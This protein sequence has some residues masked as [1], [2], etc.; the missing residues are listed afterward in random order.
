MEEDICINHNILT[1]NI[2]PHYHDFIEFVYVY[3]GK[4]VHSIDGK[5][6]PL[7]RGDLAIINYNQKHSIIG[8]SGSEYYD[9][10]I[11]PQFISEQINGAQDMYALLD[12]PQYED[13]KKCI[14]KNHCVSN[15]SMEERAKIQSII[16]LLENE[17]SK[18]KVGYELVIHSGINLLLALVFRKL[19]FQTIT[20]NNSASKKILDYIKEHCHERLSLETLS[21]R[22]HYNPSYFSRMFKKQTGLTFTQYLKKVRIERA[23][24]LLTTTNDK[25]KNICLKVGYSN[26]TKFFHDFRKITNTSPFKYRKSKK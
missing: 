9:I 25:V 12:I 20:C 2:E 22:C 13:F 3:S 17:L 14:N 16:F 4:C 21:S 1:G 7:C 11:K 15:F 10:L 6:Y 24:E 23:C 26:Q 19:S 18:R 8:E 5:Y